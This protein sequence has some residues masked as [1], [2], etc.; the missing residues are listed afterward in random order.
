MQSLHL[1][2]LVGREHLAELRREAQ[3]RHLV[4]AALAVQQPGQASLRERLVASSGQVL[5]EVGRRMLA[6]GQQPDLPR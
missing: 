1:E 2:E 6:R 3:H 5:I 4:R